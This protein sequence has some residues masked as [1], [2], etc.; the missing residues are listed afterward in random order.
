[1]T[2]AQ[3]AMP[4][5]GEVVINARLLSHGTRTMRRRKTTGRDTGVTLIELMISMLLGLVV[6]GGA[7][8]VILANRQSYR[9]NEALSQIQESSRTAFELLARDVREAGVT[10]CDSRGRV[11]NVL[12][13]R[14]GLFWWQT[15]FGIFGSEGNQSSGAA[16]FGTAP[17]TR[18][19]GTDSIT[20]Q[21]IQGT[22][23]TVES[24]QANSANFRINTATTSIANDDILIVCDF[25]H[26]AIFQVSNY[27]SNNR[28]VVHNTGHGTPGNC[29][30]GLGYPTPAI[31]N[32]GNA[33][34][35]VYSFGLNS[36][37]ARMAATAW[38]IGNNGR[39]AEG[40]RS[41]YRVRMGAAA[42]SATEE[43]VPGV[44]D[45]RLQYREQGRSDFRDANLVSS[46]SNVN[47]VRI[48]LTMLSA[49]Q[50]VA[51]NVTVDSGRL[52]R[53]FT[54]IVALRNRVP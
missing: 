40:G 39:S 38:Y 36:Q 7:T 20:L 13:P 51:T 22:G 23:L 21:G 27:N 29:F 48:E 5:A 16:S 46:W 45:M 26:A 14:G 28:T 17:G 54:T 9:T 47:A 33:N 50:R 25:D 10:G 53:D 24:H 42:A 3:N 2:Y 35:N 19:A 43:V 8:G 4:W 18:V 11:A 52:R 32:A 44:T 37:I 49:D 15:W 1:L 41:L 12:D 6:I 30:K 34:G 31:C